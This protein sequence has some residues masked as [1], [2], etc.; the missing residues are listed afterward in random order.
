MSKN[1]ATAQEYLDRHKIPQ[2]VEHLT[3]EV[4]YHRPAQLQNQSQSFFSDQDLRAL[5]STFDRLEQGQI[6]TA[7]YLEAMKII[8]ATNA[9]QAPIQ[10][11]TPAIFLAEAQKALSSST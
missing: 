3:A 7:Q 6:T 9:N 8:G 10:P 5:Y 1:A 11:I 2:L 4:L